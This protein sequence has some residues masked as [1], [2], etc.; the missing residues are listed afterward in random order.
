MEI[1]ELNIFCRH[2]L[3]KEKGINK[4]AENQRWMYPKA[5]LPR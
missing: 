5:F 4:Q 2:I 3:L 1:D